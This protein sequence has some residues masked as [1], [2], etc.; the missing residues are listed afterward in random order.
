[1]INI[2]LKDEYIDSIQGEKLYLYNKQ[3][4][5]ILCHV[6]YCRIYEC[7]GQNNKETIL[8]NIEIKIGDEIYKLPEEEYRF[9]KADCFDEFVGCDIKFM[10]TLNVTLFDN[11]YYIDILRPSKISKVSLNKNEVMVTHFTRATETFIYSNIKKELPMMFYDKVKHM[12]KYKVGHGR[13]FTMTLQEAYECN[14]GRIN[15]R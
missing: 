2:A 1:M 3:R 5:T 8:R 12:D 14:Y 4:V 6:S 11:E 13:Y 7:L 9:D 10:A 15:V